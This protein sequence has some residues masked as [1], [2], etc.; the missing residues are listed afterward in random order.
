M[1][2]YSG[3][4][5][6]S[7]SYPDSVCIDGRLFDA[8]ACDDNGK[9]HEPGEYIPCPVCRPTDAVTREIEALSDAED[10]G[11]GDILAAA[12]AHIRDRRAHHGVFEPFA[13]PDGVNP[14]NKT[15]G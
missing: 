1:C 14:S 6:G 5:F 4:E 10:A 9:L 8:D 3:Y 15:Q 11:D 2:N 7:M 12:I 13:P